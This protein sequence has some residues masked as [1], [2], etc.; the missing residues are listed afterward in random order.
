MAKEIKSRHAVCNPLETSCSVARVASFTW[1]DDEPSS[2]ACIISSGWGARIKSAYNGLT[3]NNG[4]MV[5]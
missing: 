2:T 1:V 5:A 3:S 4:P